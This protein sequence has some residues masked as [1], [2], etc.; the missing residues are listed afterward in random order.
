[1]GKDSIEKYHLH[2]GEL[3]DWELKARKVS[4]KELSNKT[5]FS[6]EVLEEIIEQKS[7]M[8]VEIANSIEKTLGIPA[9]IFIGLQKNYDAAMVAEKGKTT[10]KKV[11]PTT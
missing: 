9:Y 2:P 1:M 7:Q 11:M 10:R 8:T 4:V 5:G 3:L 6:T